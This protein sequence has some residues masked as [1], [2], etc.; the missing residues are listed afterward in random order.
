MLRKETVRTS[1]A[2][3][4]LLDEADSDEFALEMRAVRGLENGTCGLEIDRRSRTITIRDK[5]TGKPVF[6]TSIAEY[7]QLLE[8]RNVFKKSHLYEMKDELG[9]EH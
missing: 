8:A 4:R 2:E 9:G 6:H 7:E 5:V 3:A 1:D